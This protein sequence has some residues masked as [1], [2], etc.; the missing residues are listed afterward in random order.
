MAIV[1]ETQFF[2][3]NMND[4]VPNVLH[5]QFDPHRISDLDAQAIYMVIVVIFDVSFQYFSQT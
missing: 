3:A 2:F 5:I 4:L 1:L